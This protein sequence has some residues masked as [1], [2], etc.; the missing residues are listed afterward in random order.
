M[1]N[2]IFQ[3]NQQEAAQIGGS[4]YVTKSGGYDFKIVRA[5]FVNNKSL[6]LDLETREGLKC[7]YVSIN[8]TKNDGSLNDYGNKMI[9]AIM[10]C[11]GAQQLTADQQGNVP[12]L[13]GK[14]LKAV[15]QRVDYTK[16]SG[17]N[18]GQ[19]GYKFDFKMPANLQTGKTVKEQLDNS[20]AKAFNQYASTITDKDERSATGATPCHNSPSQAQYNEP[21]TNFDDDIAF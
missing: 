7:N 17:A 9:M 19:D 21:P 6:E 16:Q 13:F 10:G 5:Q 1:N 20:E 18:A 15:V 3:Y 4:Q 14:Y 2:V 11:V 12:E 8:Y